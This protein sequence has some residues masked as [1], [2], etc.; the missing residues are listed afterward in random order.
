M[1][2][3][4]AGRRDV[5]RC[6]GFTLVELVV[7]MVIMAII[8]SVALASYRSFS[9][10]SRRATATTALSDAASRQEQF[11]L[12][13][14]RYTT[15]LGD[16]GLNVPA[17]VDGGYYQ[18]GIVAATAACPIARCWVMRAVPQGTQAEDSCGTL[19]YTSEGDRTPAECW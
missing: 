3:F 12:N 1:Y 10:E 5:A 11:Y 19:T 8:S 16:D 18:I 9:L 4:H 6:G 7:A 13:N 17:L 14:K 15:S 2:R